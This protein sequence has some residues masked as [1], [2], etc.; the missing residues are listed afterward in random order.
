MSKN[1]QNS[2]P[3]SSG[4]PKANRPPQR[5]Y[6]RVQPIWK[7]KFIQIL[8][9]T[10]GVLEATV[11]KLE[12]EP[13]PGTEETPG[14]WSVLLGKI[15]SLLPTSLSAKLSDTALTGVIAVLTV[16]LVWT[17]ST[18]L[19]GKSTEVAS[20]PP[21]EEKTVPPTE[22]IPEPRIATAPEI[23]APPEEAQQPE[24][25]TP[26]PEPEPEI[27]PEP[28][29]TPEPTP[30]P[31][32]TPTPIILTPEQTLIAA[33]ENQVAEIS[34]RF[35]Q[36]LIKSI[37]AN[38]GTSNLTVK[39]SDDWYTLKESQQNNLAAEIL[40][41]SKELDF[42]HLEITDLQGIQVA[43]NP[44]VGTEMVIFKRR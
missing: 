7:V 11:E 17:T 42:S 30:E 5:P 35:A 37:Q 2:Q 28:E 15:R 31:E 12:T 33:I 39:I 34:D 21:A 43:R 22:E 16:V 36:G 13:P 1:N 9:G 3:P 14:F 8:R 32:P 20:V 18:V 10:I 25:I 38:F 27:T 4:E 6:Q 29:P 26:S 19:I 41:R 44:V 23:E 24:E 40:Q